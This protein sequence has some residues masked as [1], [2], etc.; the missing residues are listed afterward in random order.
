MAGPRTA[1][2]TVPSPVRVGR[3][4]PP[5]RPGMY[6]ERAMVTCVRPLAAADASPWSLSASR[7]ACAPPGRPASSRGAPITGGADAPLMESALVPRPAARTRWPPA[8]INLFI[9]HIVILT[10][11]RARPSISA[12]RPGSVHE[13]RP[14]SAAGPR[15]ANKLYQESL[16]LLW[17]CRRC[18]REP[19]AGGRWK[20]LSE[21]LPSR[22]RQRFPRSHAGRVARHTSPGSRDRGGGGPRRDLRPA[23]G[24]TARVSAHS[25]RDR[26]P[27]GRSASCRPE[28]EG[29]GRLW[30]ALPENT[31]HLSP[32]RSAARRGDTHGADTHSGDTRGGGHSGL[33]PRA[34]R[35][36]QDLTSRHPSR[37]Q[38]SAPE[39]EVR[40]FLVNKALIG[41]I[42]FT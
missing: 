11:N 10:T 21:R 9:P 29:R 25:D 8:V 31:G 41:R 38:R 15:L 17:L 13:S 16:A 14:G 40:R 12:P 24:A 20:H 18:R 30:R 32:W 39:C 28:G 34:E 19:G 27:S 22:W 35:P 37:R 33:G 26:H 42:D 2:S 6:G 3:A 4:A 1:I 5:A 36:R 23:V 7:T